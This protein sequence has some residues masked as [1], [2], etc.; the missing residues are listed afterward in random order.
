MILGRDCTLPIVRPHI[1]ANSSEKK[2]KI[3]TSGEERS[4]IDKWPV[5]E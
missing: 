1:L 2:M 5:D 3:K 4:L